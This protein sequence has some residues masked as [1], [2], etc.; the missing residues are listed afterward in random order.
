VIA[1]AAPAIAL[2]AAFPVLHHFMTVYNEPSDRTGAV[3]FVALLTLVPG[4]A[5]ALFVRNKWLF[6]AGVVW[7]V[8]AAV[9]AAIQVAKTDDAQAGLALLGLPLY[10]GV[11]VVT[12]A[13]IQAGRS[14]RSGAAP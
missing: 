3:I 1:V 12:L 2:G 10:M 14:G 9:F 8:V 5:L 4:V 6:S 11:G 13:A 7:S